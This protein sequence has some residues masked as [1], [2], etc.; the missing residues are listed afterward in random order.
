MEASLGAE[1]ILYDV[2]AMVFLVIILGIFIPTRAITTQLQ[3]ANE[4][5]LNSWQMPSQT[6]QS[7]ENRKS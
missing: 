3:Q 7:L 4:T 5:S 1:R 2:P 6:Q